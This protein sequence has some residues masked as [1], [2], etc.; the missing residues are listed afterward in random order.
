MC[1]SAE[2]LAVGAQ[3]CA[4]WVM[5][6]STSR[7]LEA[8]S[9]LRGLRAPR[10]KLS[11]LRLLASEASRHQSFAT[12]VIAGSYFRH[13]P[14]QRRHG[15]RLTVPS[16]VPCACLLERHKELDAGSSSFRSHLPSFASQS[17]C[18]GTAAESAF[19]TCA[20]GSAV[21]CFCLTCS[22]EAG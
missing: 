14:L 16:L 6:A 5:W 11:A 1:N 20:V 18:C 21:A 17:C 4:G 9:G 13:E 10:L 7:Q 12:K 19:K 3:P 15:S 2:Q 22:S 8:R